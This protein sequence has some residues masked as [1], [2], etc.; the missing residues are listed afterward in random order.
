[1]QENLKLVWQNASNRKKKETEN[2]PS[3]KDIITIKDI[4]RRS[5]EIKDQVIVVKLSATI[6]NNNELLTAF[7]ESIQLLEMCGAKISIVHDHIDLENSPLKTLAED[8]LNDRIGAIA[9]NNP[10]IMEMILSGYVNKLIVSKL[11]SVG[12]YAIGIS[13]KDTNLLQA[14]KSKLSH[15][16]TTNQD[17]IDIGFISEPIMINPEI[18]LNFEDNNIIPVISPIAN[19]E[20]ENTH[21][22][23][24]DLT[25]AVISAALGADHLILPYEPSKSLAPDIKAQDVN[26]FK[27]M[28]NDN[29]NFI[30]AELI[31][32]AVNAIENNIGCV[33]FVSDTAPNSVLLT[34]FTK[35][36]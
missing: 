22:L 20:Q 14:K 4:I 16:R 8:N 29:N 35:Y 21:L 34:M 33:H 10:I 27:A 9:H 15:R 17:V 28:L 13:G 19:D 25:T 31:E 32:I 23:N 30:K 12:C 7:A 6:I 24:A 11:C 26:V 3:L 5:N 2:I 18:L 36:K 1:M